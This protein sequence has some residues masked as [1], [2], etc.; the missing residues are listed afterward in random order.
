MKS[1][2]NTT[3]RARAAI[4][5]TLWAIGLLCVGFY[6]VSKVH[7]ANAQATAISSME[8]QWNPDLASEPDQALWSQQRIASHEQSRSDSGH[9]RPLALLTI[10]SVDIR[11]AVF[12][13]TSD[14]ILDLGVGR[15]PGTGRVG[16]AGNLALAGHRDG[17]FRGLKDISI[18]DDVSIQDTFATSQ[19][20]VTDLMI[21][22]PEDVS[23]LAPT[24]HSV[25]T[26]I[27]CYPFYFVG[28]APKRF[29]VRA[30]LKADENEQYEKRRK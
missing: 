11:V 3:S 25:I 12:E 19:Y 26:L 18:G 24:D 14:R 17:F 10:P 5:A 2:E 1:N 28:N 15:V 29:I 27:T 9:M 23:V 7:T 8:S 22:E 30:V 6:G 13:G 21:V 16:I 20:T 4:E